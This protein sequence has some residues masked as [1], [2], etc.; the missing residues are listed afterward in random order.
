MN[1]L[2]G[3]GGG[4]GGRNDDVAGTLEDYRG[5]SGV[6]GA[7]AGRGG[8]A[9]PRTKLLYVT[10]EKLAKSGSLTA[11]LKAL[12][13]RWDGSSGG[14]GVYGVRKLLRLFFF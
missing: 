8:G 9:A 12:A 14:R 2:L 10:P 5:G 3:S 4:G 11:A 1:D 6:A 13:S 7:G